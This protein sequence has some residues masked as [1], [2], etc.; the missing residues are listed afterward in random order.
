[1]K[2]H[3]SARKAA[4]LEVGAVMERAELK[5]SL[6]VAD[7]AAP[8]WLCI[9]TTAASEAEIAATRTTVSDHARALAPEI[10]TAFRVR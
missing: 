6:R 7:G 3:Q 1:M 8:K 2:K 4:F 5:R 10:N 9:K